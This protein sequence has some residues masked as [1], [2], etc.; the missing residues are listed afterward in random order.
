LRF[1]IGIPLIIIGTFLFSWGVKTLG[2]KNT[3]GIK[4]RFIQS[5]PYQFT[6][7]PQYLGGIIFF[8]G[9]I[10]TT[11]SL[12]V[13]ITHILLILVYI[14]APLTEEIWLEEQYG[15]EYISYMKKVPRFT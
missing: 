12:Y 4:E 13:L 5:G 11:N 14:I 9:M 3:S 15:E 1:L 10:I 6:R 7:N 2:I 8:F